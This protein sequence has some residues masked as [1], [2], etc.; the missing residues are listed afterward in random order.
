MPSLARHA[1]CFI[2]CFLL[3]LC[4]TDATETCDFESATYGPYLEDIV[5]RVM[6]G[7]PQQSFSD[8]V[9]KCALRPWCK[10]LGYHRMAL[11]CELH[12]DLKILEHISAF[13][14]NP[15]TMMYIRREDL[16]T[17]VSVIKLIVST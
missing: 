9:K 8:C 16:K 12:F 4:S 3:L 7:L 13:G 17:E 11:V 2:G 5:E 15:K 6:I 10:L 1:L 14:G